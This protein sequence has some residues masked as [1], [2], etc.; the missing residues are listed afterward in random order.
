[1]NA[2]AR[3]PIDVAAIERWA[4]GAYAEFSGIVLGDE[5]SRLFVVRGT[6]RCE[7]ARQL[8]LAWTPQEAIARVQ[9]SSPHFV[10]VAEEVRLEVPR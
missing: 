5:H 6:G 1:M 7:G 2:E 4:R 3:F 8:V 9:R 10:G